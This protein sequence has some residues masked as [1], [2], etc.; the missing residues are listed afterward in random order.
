VRLLPE[1][2]D[3]L[4]HVNDES[5]HREAVADDE[6]KRQTCELS[7]VTGGNLS[8]RRNVWESFTYGGTVDAGAVTSQLVVRAISGCRVERRELWWSEGWVVDLEG[9]SNRLFVTHVFEKG[10]VVFGTSS[11]QIH[12]VSVGGSDLDILAAVK[13]TGREFFGDKEIGRFYGK[14]TGGGLLSGR[15]IEESGL[16]WRAGECTKKIAEVVATGWTRCDEVL[17]LVEIFS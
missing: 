15:D 4:H 3:H 9:A 11:Y 10:S 12:G 8:W 2:P 1:T 6:N 16:V 7:D 13:K 14:L 5:Q 17:C